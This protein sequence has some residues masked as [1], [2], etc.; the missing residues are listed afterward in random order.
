LNK[1]GGLNK[2]W[3]MHDSDLDNVRGHPRFADLL[4]SFPD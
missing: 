3:L 1:V 4:A 2:E